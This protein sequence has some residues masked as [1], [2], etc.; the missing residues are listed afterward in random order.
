MGF[1]EP[2]KCAYDLHFPVGIPIYS[3]W[4]FGLY[5]IEAILQGRAGLAYAQCPALLR[6]GRYHTSGHDC[7]H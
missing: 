2:V 7:V 5:R 3:P 1:L 4:E 6:A